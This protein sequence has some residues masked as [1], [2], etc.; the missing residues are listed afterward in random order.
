MKLNP[1]SIEPQWDKV[2]IRQQKTPEK[3]SGGIILADES[4]DRKKFAEI[5]G[6]VVSL[7]AGAFRKE[8]LYFGETPPKPGDRVIFA[9]YAGS[10]FIDEFADSDEYGYRL[11]HDTDIIAIIK[12]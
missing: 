6:E 7:G 1:A 4:K 12:E 8:N 3:T 9:K 10:N 2:L 5:T 11:V